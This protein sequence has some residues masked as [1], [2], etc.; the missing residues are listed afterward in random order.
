M[1]EHNITTDSLSLKLGD[2]TFSREETAQ[3]AIAAAMDKK[4]FR[5]VLLDLRAQ[6]AFTEFF[7]IVS[8]TNA[9][10]VSAVAEGVRMFFKNTFGLNP[11]AVDGLESQTWVLIDYGF[12]FVHVFQEPTRELYQLEQLWSKGR[13]VS[14]SEEAVQELFNEAKAIAPADSGAEA[15]AADNR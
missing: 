13:L 14:L 15:S 11:V 2:R 8:A 4:A 6:G 1:T 9:R 7:A 3:L 12:L 10:Q 5:P